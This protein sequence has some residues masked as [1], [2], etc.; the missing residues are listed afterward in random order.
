MTRLRDSGLRRS[1]RGPLKPS[2]FANSVSD[3]LAPAR[4]TRARCLPSLPTPHISLVQ[5]QRLVH[6]QDGPKAALPVT[7]QTRFD[8]LSPESQAYLRSVGD[9]VRKHGAA[10][11]DLEGI[12]RLREAVPARVARQGGAAAVRRAGAARTALEAEAEALAKLRGEVLRALREAEG[13]YHLHQRL[14]ARAAAAQA[15]QPTQPP[16]EA[17]APPRLPPPWLVDAVARFEAEIGGI[18]HAAVQVEQALAPRRAADDALMSGGGGETA[19]LPRVVKNAN[20]YLL[21]VAARVERIVAQV[22]ERKHAHLAERRRAGDESNPFLEAEYKEKREAA[23]AKEEAMRLQ[24]AATPS[25]AA[26]QQQQQQQP[27]AAAATGALPAAVPATTPAFG[28]APAATGGLFGAAAPAATGGLFGAAAPAATGGLFGAA[29]PT[30]APGTGGSL[31]GSAPAATTAAPA[32][33]AAPAA[34]AAP[35]TGGLFGGGAAA[36]PAT[37]GLFGGGAAATPAAGAFSGFAT[38]APTLGAPAT[39]AF[40]APTSTSQRKSSRSRGRR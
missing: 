25:A 26:Q 4:L 35:A 17:L 39:P 11:E 22:N 18:A 40:G 36:A 1:A 10:A 33:G 7:A 14:R 24:G 21:R 6:K 2:S 9:A 12:S 3:A 8:E 16:A 30:A 5:V 31:F 34:S 37:G 38:P 23:R 32:F 19:M 13:A 28:A 20:D 27:V 29:A 15:Q